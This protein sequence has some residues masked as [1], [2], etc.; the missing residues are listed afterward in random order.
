MAT[1]D[2]IQ[3]LTERTRVPAD[4]VSG[5]KICIRLPQGSPETLTL[6]LGK[7]GSF[8][9]GFD[10]REA[11]FTVQDGEVN[12]TVY[13]P[14]RPG[15]TFLTGPGI[16][17]R[18]EFGAAS[19]LHAIMYE[20]VPTLAWAL[21]LA[22]VLRNFAVASYF[23]PSGSMENT[24]KPGD[25]LIADK[26]SYKVLGREPDRGDV[27]IFVYPG[28]DEHGRVDFIKRIIGLPGD[29][30]RVT[31]GE[32]YVNNEKLTEP[33][34]KEK[35]YNDFD[36]TT[37]PENQFFAMGDNRNH[38]RDSRSWGFVPRKNLEGRALFVFWPFTRAKLMQHVA[39][40]PGGQAVAAEPEAI[41]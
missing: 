32:V 18:I 41:E 7:C 24:L 27:M 35:P 15:V 23:I 30:V 34:I 22:L 10:E 17:Q 6:K 39:Y 16:K 26:F 4:G 38:S 19:H 25:L 3:V 37:V 8:E 40:T 14:R 36:E 28:K 33:Y 31:D 2:R 9:Q 29:T 12:L 13:A 11:H 20:W 5:T 1:T 21:V